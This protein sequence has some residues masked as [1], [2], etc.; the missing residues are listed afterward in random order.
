MVNY[1]TKKHSRVYL[2]IFIAQ[3]PGTQSF[4]VVI[5]KISKLQHEMNFPEATVLW[6]LE[7][8]ALT[9]FYIPHRGLRGPQCT[10]VP[11]SGLWN[12]E[13]DP[14]N[15]LPMKVPDKELNT[16]ENKNNRKKVC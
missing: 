4:Y 11:N 15:Y 10:S 12:L 1:E 2:T 14:E 9:P 6:S 3:V 8:P 7:F 5:C 16:A 13:V